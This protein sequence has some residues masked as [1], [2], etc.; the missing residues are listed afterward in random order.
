[1]RKWEYLRTE[2]GQPD[3][4]NKLGEEGWELINIITPHKIVDGINSYIN[5]EVIY[6]LKRE[7]IK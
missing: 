1:M 5:K 4:L 3:E 7:I 2:S 6:F